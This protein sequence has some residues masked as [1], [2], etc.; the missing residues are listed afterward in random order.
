MSATTAGTR[1]IGRRGSTARLIVGVVMI[2]GAAIAGIG[3]RDALLGLV[4][5]PIVTLTVILVR[6]RQH[7]PLRLTGPEGHCLNCI[8]GVLA[9][10]FLPIAALLFYGTSMLLAAAR[11]YA[12]CEL[13]A[14]S[15]TL[16]GRD[17]QIACPL[18]APID[19][20]DARTPR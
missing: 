20:L 11:G 16:L 12:G 4:V 13:F 2:V 18:F 10:V 17:D 14:V 6:G 1:Q 19:A 5:A 15:N 8:I 3:L 7:S 9:F